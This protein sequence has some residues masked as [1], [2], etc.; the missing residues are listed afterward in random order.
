MVNKLRSAIPAIPS[1]CVSGRPDYMYPRGFG[2]SIKALNL[3]PM[4]FASRSTPKFGLERLV[5]D[6][7][8]MLEDEER[9]ALA[10]EA[11]KT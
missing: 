11:V 7:V 2:S 6:A 10:R 9:K 3:E 1:V 8:K 5:H 4:R